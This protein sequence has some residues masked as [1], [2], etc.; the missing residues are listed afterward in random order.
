[1]NID[2]VRAAVNRLNGKFAEHYRD[3]VD[4]INRQLDIGIVLDFADAVLNPP[5]KVVKAAEIYRDATGIHL[6]FVTAVLAEWAMTLL[7]TPETKK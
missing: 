3:D 5:E 7:T 6:D 4:G 1:M 2:D